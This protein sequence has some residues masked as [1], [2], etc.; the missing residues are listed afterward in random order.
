M[1]TEKLPLLLIA[2]LLD[3]ATL[4]EHQTQHL[5]DLC[6]PIVVENARDATMRCMAQRAL[7][8]TAGEFAIAGMSMGGYAALEVM[9][10]APERVKGLALV[11]TSARADDEA[12]RRTRLIQMEQAKNGQFD[13]LLETTV[14][15]IVH[16]RRRTD[17]ALMEAIFAMA[18]RTGAQTYIRQQEAIMSRVDARPDLANISC[19]TL[20]IVGR[21]DIPTPPAMAEEML[22]AIPAAKLGLIEQCGH[23]SPMERPHAVTA[24][25]RL[26]LNEIGT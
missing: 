12:K 16:E 26:W 17:A 13:A 8:T 19:P 18:R 22:A 20:V 25:M 23:Y 15:L 4:W 14:P 11:N 6:R 7:D 3:D 2:G 24:L 21:E 1:G 10:L 9:R 5:G